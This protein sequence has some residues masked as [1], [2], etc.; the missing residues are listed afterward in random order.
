MAKKRL[1]LS[2]LIEMSAVITSSLETREITKRTIEAAT[3][4]LETEAGSLL[5]I[6]RDNWELFFDEALGEKGDALKGIRLPPGSGVAGWVAERGVPQL[7]KDVRK[8]KRFYRVVDDA[9]GFVTRGIACVPIIFKGKTLGVLEV[10]NKR[11]GTFCADDLDILQAL[12]NQVAVALENAR[13]YQENCRQYEEMLVAEKRLQLEKEK[14]LKDLHDGIGGLTT[15]INLL[16]E[17]GQQAATA[18]ETKKILATIAGLSR[19]GMGEIRTFMNT[20]EDTEANWSDLAAELRNYGHA[21]VEPHNITLAIDTDIDAQAK[22]PGVFLYL[23]LVRIYK[24]ALVNVIKHSRASSVTVALMVTPAEARLTIKDNGAGIA[25]SGARTG[26]GI[27]NMHSR[28]KE[29][30]GELSI[31]GGEGTVIGLHLTFP[32]PSG[33]GSWIRT[34]THETGEGS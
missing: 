13:L 11:Q 8:D 31:S 29:L 18:E 9:F 26:R 10:I 19:E 15:N 2:A 7:V 6:D 17:L 5:L 21:M 32:I 27:S 28:A 12:G 1:Q 14:L 33:D 3:R 22:P 30:G 24:E 34:T 16:S 25:A 23:S 20:L 4:L